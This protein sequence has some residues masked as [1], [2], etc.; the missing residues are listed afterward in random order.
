[1]F[2]DQVIFFAYIVIEIVKFRLFPKP[3]QFPRAAPDSFIFIIED[4]VRRLGT[5]LEQK[6]G[7]IVSVDDAIGRQLGTGQ[8]SKGRQHIDSGGDFICSR[9]GGNPSRPPGDGRNTHMAFIF[10]ATLVSAQRSHGGAAAAAVVGREYDEGIF[11]QSL[12]S[13]RFQ[14]PPNAPVH[15]LDL[16]ASDVAIGLVEQLIANKTRTMDVGVRHIKEERFFA[17]LFNKVDGSVGDH[18]AEQRLARSI[19]NVGHDLVPLNKR[20]RRAFYAFQERPHV[21]GV[22]NAKIFIESLCKRHKFRLIAEVPFPKTTGGV[23][24]GFQQ[25]G[26]RDLFGVESPFAGRE[27]D[28]TIHTYAIGIATGHQRRARRRTGCGADIVLGQPHPLGR[29]AVEFRGFVDGRAK[30]TDIAVAHIV[31]KDE[32]YVG[33]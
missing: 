31:D 13:Q 23:S 10:R 27:I 24:S 14:D 21:V 29:H 11:C 12:F 30:R 28:S 22:G 5:R 16:R 6:A 26:D 8:G 17:M 25:F 15:L 32:D 18:F 7:N 33:L 9:S 4:F 3:H 19:R 20:Q 2:F 1:M